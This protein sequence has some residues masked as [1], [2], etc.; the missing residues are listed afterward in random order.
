M[1]KKDYAPQDGGIADQVI[2]Y[3]QK[4]APNTMMSSAELCRVLGLGNKNLSPH[5]HLAITN[6]LLM[7]K[8]STEPNMPTLF[9]LS[10]EMRADIP[11]RP[12]TFWQPMHNVQPAPDPAPE[13]T[14]EPA[15]ASGTEAKVCAD[16]TARQQF[17]LNKYGV[18]VEDNPLGLRQ[19]LQHAYEE[20]LD[21]AVYL[22][23]AMD[24][25]DKAAKKP[26]PRAKIKCTT[27]EKEKP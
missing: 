8:L 2:A 7:R 22:R 13:P 3:F 15:V 9:G 4:H 11:K 27:I 18:S 16:I 10:D 5:L 25:L 26:K 17:G 1:R 24:E 19:W 23:R 21:K 12:R 20:T 14:P 6:R